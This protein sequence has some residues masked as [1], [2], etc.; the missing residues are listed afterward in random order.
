MHC[1]VATKSA[2]SG[3]SGRRG[4]SLRVSTGGAWT[5]NPTE[6]DL[7]NAQLVPTRPPQALPGGSVQTWPAPGSP[8]APAYWSTTERVAYFDTATV[9][10][11]QIVSGTCHDGTD[12]AA[13]RG[14]RRG[15]VPAGVLQLAVLQRQ[16]RR[17]ARLTYSPATFPHN[18]TGLLAVGIANTGGSVATDVHDV[19]ITLAPGFT[20]VSTASGPAPVVNGQVLTWP[21]GWA[22]SPAARRRSA[23]RSRSLPRCRARSARSSSGRTT[24]RTATA[25]ASP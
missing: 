10:H 24:R 14:E 18:G 7:P 1:S 19:S 13:L 21:A 3:Q 16:R 4:R 5:V 8:G 20:D 2:R 23:S 12:H 6:A 9:D 25:R 15:A 22:T 11:D 17:E